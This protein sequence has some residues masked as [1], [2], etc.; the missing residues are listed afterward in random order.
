M[1]F[2][3]S[4]LFYLILSNDKEHIKEIIEEIEKN[5]SNKILEDSDKKERFV[6]KYAETKEMLEQSKVEFTEEIGEEV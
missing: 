2:P 3:L 5:K 6:K 1:S 4:A